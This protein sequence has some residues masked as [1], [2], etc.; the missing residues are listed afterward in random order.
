MDEACK[1]EDPVAALLNLKICDP[2]CGGGH[3]LIA[4]AHRMGEKYKREIEG[5][6]L[7]SKNGG[8]FKLSNIGRLNTYSLFTERAIHTC[9]QLGT[10]GLIVQSGLVTD[11][12][13]KTLFRFL[14]SNSYLNSFF[15]F[16]N[17]QHLFFGVH[18]EQR[19]ALVV[20]SLSKMNTNTT[21]F[22][23][24]LTNVEDLSQKIEFLN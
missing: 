7:L 4:A 3:F 11:D 15:D 20:L 14:I 16:E 1:Q 9:K 13:N 18:P 17:K 5:L 12:S 21:K 19:F 10:V 23:F 8:Y 2:A 24:G 6:V 22:A